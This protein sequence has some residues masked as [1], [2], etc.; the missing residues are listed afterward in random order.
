MDATGTSRSHGV[1]LDDEQAVSSHRFG[2][3]QVYP[4]S[5][6]PGAT[7]AMSLPSMASTR[8][9]PEHGCTRI[10]RISDVSR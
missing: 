4:E 10:L 6:S 1:L 2:L 8:R 7:T 3:N 9:H 5:R